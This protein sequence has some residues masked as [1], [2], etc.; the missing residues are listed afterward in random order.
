MMSE[1]LSSNSPSTASS[2]P[3][4]GMPIEIRFLEGNAVPVLGT[5]TNRSAGCID[6]HTYLALHPGAP[7]QV[8]WG[9]SLGL[10]EVIQCSEEHGTFAGR[11][12]LRT[13]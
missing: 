6:V 7:V 10:G 2:T 8:T 11:S 5:V 12:N 3:E 9:D 1:S 4:C 13:S